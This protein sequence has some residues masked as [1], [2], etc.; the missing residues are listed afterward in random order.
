MGA[1]WVRVRTVRELDAQVK[2]R[3]TDIVR[4]SLVEFLLNRT[5]GSNADGEAERRQR[6]EQAEQQRQELLKIDPAPSTL[7]IDGTDR[8]ATALALNGCTAVA[9]VHGDHTIILLAPSELASQLAVQT[10][11]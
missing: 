3:P 5:S 7:R 2:H 4:S 11:S 8:D 10:V 9:S 1:G 6:L